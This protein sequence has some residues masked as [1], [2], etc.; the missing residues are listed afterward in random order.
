MDTNVIPAPAFAGVNLSPR[1]RG[2]GIYK[3]VDSRLCGNDSG[4]IRQ[5]EACPSDRDAYYCSVRIHSDDDLGIAF[6]SIT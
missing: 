4:K 1:R 2:A 3:K 5:S 6:V